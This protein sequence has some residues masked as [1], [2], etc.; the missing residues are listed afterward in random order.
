[1]TILMSAL[2]WFPHH[3]RTNPPECSHPP[4]APA[5]YHECAMQCGLKAPGIS[6]ILLVTALCFVTIRESLPLTPVAAEAVEESKS[7]SRH[8]APRGAL[9]ASGHV[10]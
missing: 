4:M 8:C 2:D 10:W 9:A 5:M 7:G 1:M 6:T 3:L